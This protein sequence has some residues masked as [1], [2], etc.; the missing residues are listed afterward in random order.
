MDWRAE[1]AL[2]QSFCFSSI[3]PII[4]L[5]FFSLPNC[6][7]S[8]YFLL[9]DATPRAIIVKCD[10]RRVNHRCRCRMNT[11]TFYEP[12]A[13]CLKEAMGCTPPPPP[14]VECILFNQLVF[15]FRKCGSWEGIRSCT[16]QP[17]LSQQW[18]IGDGSRLGTPVKRYDM[19]SLQTVPYHIAGLLALFC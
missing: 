3:F 18:S 7:I 15:Q 9:K 10:G 11:C 13:Q 4:S 1:N 2:D 8:Y 14:L 5:F 6:P 17:R 19:T 12:F 16:H